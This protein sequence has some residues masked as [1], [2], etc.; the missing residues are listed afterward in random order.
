MLNKL[1][2]VTIALFFCLTVLHTQLL[3]SSSEVSPE[4]LDLEIS[5]NDLMDEYGVIGCSLTVINDNKNLIN[6]NYGFAN[7]D[8]YEMMTEHHSIRLASVSKLLTSILFLKIAENNRTILTKDVSALID[9]DFINPYYPETP[10]T[11]VELLTHT[12]SYYPYL[13]YAKNFVQRS[14][15]GKNTKISELTSPSGQYYKKYFWDKKFPPGTK[16]AYSS[17]NFMVL[18]TAIEKISGKRF[19]QLAKEIL[20]NKLWLTHTHLPTT[21]PFAKTQYATGYRMYNNVP[22]ESINDKNFE[23]RKMNPKI[24]TGDNATIHS[25]QAG[26]RSNI[27]DLS[28]VMIMLLNKGKYKVQRILKPESVELL[29]TVQYKQKTIHRGLGAEINYYLIPGL[30]MV[31]HTGNAYGTISHFFYNRE[32]DFG[33][34]FVINGLKKNTMSGSHFLIEKEIDRLIYNKLFK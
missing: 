31:G 30:K 13:D 27:T 9:T 15:S 11:P 34:I 5:L 22:N 25:P 33:V 20:I 2:W 19:D 24:E 26:F 32:H 18:A 17:Y 12:S 8:E 23:I 29:E 21:Y 3:V 10:I 7:I 1:K 6:Y 4:I 16:Y 28:K 14:I